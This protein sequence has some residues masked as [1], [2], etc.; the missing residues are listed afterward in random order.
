MTFRTKDL[1][2]LE[3]FYALSPQQRQLL[4]ERA[5]AKRRWTVP[6]LV[7]SGLCMVISM[8][9]A[10]DPPTLEYSGDAPVYLAA[11]VFGV[12][13]V[14]LVLGRFAWG[15][16]R[17]IF[18]GDGDPKKLRGAMSYNPLGGC[19]GLAGWLAVTLLLMGYPLSEFLDGTFSWTS[20]G[21]SLV[22]VL[23]LPCG[24]AAAR[25]SYN[26]FELN[27]P[28]PAPPAPPPQGWPNQPQ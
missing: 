10:F 19:L 8:V 23:A 28:F 15:T 17:R 14:S 13:L 2:S 16:A 27:V 18:A 25:L 1:G 6:W 20:A 4:I 24:F 3:W 22:I 21:I 5:D 11:A 9:L 12:D 7:L 26:A